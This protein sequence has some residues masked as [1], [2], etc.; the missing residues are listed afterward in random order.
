MRQSPI[1]L[2]ILILVSFGNVHSLFPWMKLLWY[3]QAPHRFSF[4]RLLYPPNITCSLSMHWFPHPTPP[5]AVQPAF[6][7]LHHIQQNQMEMVFPLPCVRQYNPVINL[8][9]LWNKENIVSHHHSNRLS[10]ISLTKGQDSLASE[11]AFQDQS[12]CLYTRLQC[13]TLTPVGHLG[14]L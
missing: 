4:S 7:P 1:T 8:D 14:F 5:P 13:G 11:Q 6:G 10:L 9:E 3:T 12:C 2:G